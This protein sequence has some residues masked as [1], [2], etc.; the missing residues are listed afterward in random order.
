MVSDR[1]RRHGVD[2]AHARPPVRSARVAPDPVVA[3]P[4]GDD[5]VGQRLRRIRRR[6]RPSRSSL[7][8]QRR[9]R[10]RA[11][12]DRVHR[13]QGDR[14]EAGSVRGGDVGVR[15]LASHH[16][17]PREP[18]R[19]GRGVR[20][21][22]PRVLLDPPSRAPLA[23]AVG[24]TPDPPLL[25]RILVHHRGP[26][27]LDGGPVQAAPRPVGPVDRLPPG[28]VRR[29]GRRCARRRAAP[30]HRAP[31]RHTSR[32]PLGGHP[33]GPP[34]PPRLEPLLPR[35][36][37]RVDAERVGPLVRHVRARVRAGPLRPRRRPPAHDRTRHAGRR[38]PRPPS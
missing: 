27:A 16:A 30:A 19:L 1:H 33:V 38:L 6:R 18:A 10:V 23:G 20:R 17:R 4:G 7:P 25:H 14:V 9:T 24:V 13:G 8:R 26:H 29:D 32:R 37:L 12:R 5:G 11:R 15:T 28:G 34:G 3:R 2:H 36:Q 21:P 22:R 31:P 35:S